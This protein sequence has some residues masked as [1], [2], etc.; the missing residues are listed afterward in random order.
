MDFYERTGI[1]ALG[2]RLR[3]L[4]E[5][6]TQDSLG[7]YQLEQLDFEPKWFPVYYTLAHTD[8]L[9]VTEIAE[10]I[11]HSHPSVSQIAREMRKKGL[12][13]TLKDKY[14][15]R[16]NMLALSEYGKSIQPK[17]DKLCEYV[18][19][20]VWGL[21]QETEHDIWQAIDDLENALA[22]KSLLNRVQVIRKKSETQQ[23]RIVDYTAVYRDDFRRLNEDWI[24]RY[25]KMEEA[26]H[27]ALGDPDNYIINKG[28]YIFIALYREKP[29]G[30]CAMIKMSDST[31]ELAKMAVDPEAQ[32]KGIGGLLAQAI[33]NKAKNLGANRLFLE[34]NTKMEAAIHLYYK[35]GFK[36]I[37]GG[38]ISPYE[39]SNIKMELFL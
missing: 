14:D 18:H 5:T 17:V 21:L 10:Q 39:R 11:G 26:D 32:G 3:R 36:K 2:S 8:P 4:S 34:S 28:G 12:L 20:G 16:K 1:M 19:Q 31:Y 15:G 38:P 13:V 33:I 35:L 7:I 23:V 37:V 6:I 27:K 22:Q 25:F 29:V 24:T 9:S 30:A